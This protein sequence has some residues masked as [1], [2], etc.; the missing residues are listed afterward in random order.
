M[1]SLVF[2]CTYSNSLND[3]F[4]FI[5]FCFYTISFN[6]LI[7]DLRAVYH[8]N[9]LFLFLVFIYVNFLF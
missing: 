4:C 2:I 6:R 5:K 1:D 9:T 8:E 3:K 7:T